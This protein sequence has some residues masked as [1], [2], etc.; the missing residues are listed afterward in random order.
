MIRLPLRHCRSVGEPTDAVSTPRRVVGPDMQPTRHPPWQSPPVV[1]FAFAGATI[2]AVELWLISQRFALTGVALLDDWWYVVVANPHSFPEMLK[3][4]FLDVG[5]DP[6]GRFRPAIALW[7]YV[8]WQLTGAPGSVVGSQAIQVIRQAFF[9][10]VVS[11]LPAILI[12]RRRKQ[13]SPWMLVVLALIPAAVI[14]ASSALDL[15]LFARSGPQ[16]PALVA[17]PIAGGVLLAWWLKRRLGRRPVGARD[18]AAL[19]TGYLLLSIGALEKE[20]S[21]AFL[22]LVPFVVIDLDRHWRAAGLLRR[23][24]V[25]TR[26]FQVLAAACALPFLREFSGIVMLF[27]RG[28]KGAIYASTTTSGSGLLAQSRHYFSHAWTDQH[29][30]TQKVTGLLIVAVVLLV[31]AWRRRQGS[32]LLE[33]GLVLTAVVFLVLQST[34]ADEAPRYALPTVALLAIACASLIARSG[35]VVIAVAGVAVVVLFVYAV[36]A[37]PTL[38]GFTQQ[39]EYGV[40]GERQIERYDP[41]NCPVYM[42]SMTGA[43]ALAFPRLAGTARTSRCAPD[44]A[45]VLLTDQSPG[46]ASWANERILKVCAPPGWVPVWADGGFFIATCRTFRTGALGGQSVARILRDDR[47]VP[48]NVFLPPAKG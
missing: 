1:A 14:L 30:L 44:V 37:R 26:Q 12:W 23:P 17:E 38:V 48:S 22:V 25:R 41:P 40:I 18:V 7:S 34:G 32:I 28:T 46:A 6:G 47:L 13:L 19:V 43:S 42:A 33:V 29:E 27:V 5:S 35:A 10:G 16:E 20:A 31:V 45:G 24:L 8:Q 2:F 4:L 39:L 11:V 15:E 21:L 9:L 3:Q 36:R